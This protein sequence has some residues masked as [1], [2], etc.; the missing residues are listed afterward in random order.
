MVVNV[1]DSAVLRWEAE[2]GECLGAHGTATLA[3]AV[4]D[5]KLNLLPTK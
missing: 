5:S 3:Y 1:H 2:L 4:A